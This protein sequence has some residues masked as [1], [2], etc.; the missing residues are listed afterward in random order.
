MI[1]KSWTS[2]SIILISSLDCISQ[3]FSFRCTNGKTIPEGISI[4]PPSLPDQLILKSICIYPLEAAR[5]D[6]R[7]DPIGLEISSMQVSYFN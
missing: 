2:L 1:T 7:F 6:R 4:T 5:I 3:S